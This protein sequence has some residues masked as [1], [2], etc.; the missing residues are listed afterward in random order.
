MAMLI[1]ALTRAGYRVLVPIG[2]QADWD[3]VIYRAGTFARVQ[4]RT[5][6]IANDVVRFKL[7]SVTANGRRQ[8]SCVDAIDFCAV[9]CPDNGCCYLVPR[10][11]LPR[12]ECYLRLG[13]TRSGRKRGVRWARDYVLQR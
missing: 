13:A 7:Y 8:R 5:G 3:V 2:D 1:G 12:W 11:K 9:Y 4:C 6:R 10:A